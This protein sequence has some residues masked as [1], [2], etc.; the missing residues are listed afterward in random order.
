MIGNLIPFDRPWHNGKTRGEL[1]V[2]VDD[3]AS[4]HLT[5]ASG[6]SRT[7]TPYDYRMTEASDSLPG[8][9]E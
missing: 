8:D 1:S 7:V 4:V 5:T 9:G 2:T 3:N 6:Q